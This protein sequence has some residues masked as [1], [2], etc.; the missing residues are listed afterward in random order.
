[1]KI[2]SLLLAH[3][4][5]TTRT[6][7][8]SIAAGKYVTTIV[9][10]SFITGS[11]PLKACKDLPTLILTSDYPIQHVYGNVVSQDPAPCNCGRWR[12]YRPWVQPGRVQKAASSPRR[13]TSP[14]ASPKSGARGSRSK[15]TSP[16]R[17]TPSRSSMRRSIGRVL[18]ERFL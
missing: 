14:R 1:M 6:H 5:S 7:P 11:A 4:T 3:A 13:S 2:Q 17:S 16:R 12:S 18:R 9:T 8:D 10:K 15:S